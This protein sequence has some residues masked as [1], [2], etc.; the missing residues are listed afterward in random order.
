MN[1]LYWYNRKNEEFLG[2]EEYYHHIKIVRDFPEDFNVIYNK[3]EDED[4]SDNDIYKQL[5]E[6]GWIRIIISSSGIILD[7]YDSIAMDDVINEFSEYFY[8]DFLIK[9]ENRKEFGYRIIK[10]SD[11]LNSNS[12]LEAIR[13]NDR[14]SNYVNIFKLT[15]CQRES[16]LNKWSNMRLEEIMTEYWEGFILNPS[17][18]KLIPINEGLHWE[19]I[20]NHPTLFELSEEEEETIL[21]YI[22][23][24]QIDFAESYVAKLVRSK[25]WVLIRMMSR[26]R[27]RMELS[28]FYNEGSL[29]GSQLDE[30]INH[31]GLSGEDIVILDGLFFTKFEY[32]RFDGDLSAIKKNREFRRFRGRETIMDIRSLPD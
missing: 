28:I 1:A 24:D 7:G 15:A 25:N 20:I 6:Q 12:L 9:A 21:N 14:L 22:K 32:D 11:Y 2:G 23:N 18:M 4:S 26:E 10:Y 8:N 17:N 29:S 27:G 30:I 13:K 3:N 5:Y 19:F 31:F 16:L